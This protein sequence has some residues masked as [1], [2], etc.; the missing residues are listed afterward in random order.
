ML[1]NKRLGSP[2]RVRGEGVFPRLL[3]FRHGITPACA[4][5]S[6]ADVFHVC[7]FWDHPRVCGEKSMGKPLTSRRRGSPPRVR[8]EA[9]GALVTCDP[10]RIT[11]ACAGRSSFRFRGLR[12]GEDHPRVCGEKPHGLA[13]TFDVEGSPPRVRGED[14]MQCMIR[15]IPRITPACAGRSLRMCFM[16]R[17]A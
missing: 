15:G 10:P 5:R 1:K 12:C 11:P 4:G 9:E 13:G 16:L 14:R 8:G 2:P 17:C 7:S 6:K 3:H